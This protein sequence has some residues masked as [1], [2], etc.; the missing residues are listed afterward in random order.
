[1]EW[2]IIHPKEIWDQYVNPVWPKHSELTEKC[3]ELSRHTAVN[4]F[5]F[6]LAWLK[7]LRVKKQYNY[8][9]LRIDD[10]LICTFK[11]VAENFKLL[12]SLLK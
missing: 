3:Q 6:G 8:H 9:Y 1:M 5:Y 7:N 2:K 10:A 11:F 4:S 12:V